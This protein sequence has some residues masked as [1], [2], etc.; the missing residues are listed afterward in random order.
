MPHVTTNDGYRLQY[1]EQGQGEP[2]VLIHGW[3]QSAAMFKHQLAGLSDSF[4]VITID[5][6]GHGDSDKPEHGYRI[7]RLAKDVYDALA[8]LELHDVNLLGWSMG[9][10]VVWSYLDLFGPE[11]LSRLILVDEPS[12][13]MHTPDQTP[14]DIANT[15]AIIDAAGL[16]GLYN[17]L[18]TDTAA[19]VS[20]FVGGMVTKGIPEDLKAWIIAE[21][22]KMPAEYAARLVLNHGSLDWRD[23]IPRITLPTLVIGGKHSHVNPQ[24]QVWIHEQING[25]QLEIFDE[26]GA[27]FMFLEAPERFN[28]VVRAFLK[29]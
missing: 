29:G 9:C 17:A 3:S 10:S 13:V 15:G 1:Q 5:L 23:V 2:L 14:D 25:S 12:W 19:T 11:R 16:V 4:R 21:N 22:L 26:G 24:S 18:R 28:E 7:S 27:H 20:G 8:E 6:R